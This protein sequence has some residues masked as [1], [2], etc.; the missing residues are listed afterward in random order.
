MIQEEPPKAFFYT[1][2]S[3]DMQ[4]VQSGGCQ[5]FVEMSLIA[6]RNHTIKITVKLCSHT[7][8]FDLHTADESHQS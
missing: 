7:P 1:Q 4:K 3:Y 5:Q 2:L 6:G 8:A